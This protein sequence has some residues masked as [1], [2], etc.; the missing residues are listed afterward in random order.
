MHTITLKLLTKQEANGSRITLQFASDLK[1]DDQQR[2]TAKDICSIVCSD[3]EL[4]S[5]FKELQTGKDFEIEIR[6]LQ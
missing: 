2:A 1:Q 5:S 6:P 3:P 4:F